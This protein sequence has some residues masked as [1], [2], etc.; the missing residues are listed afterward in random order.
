MN[1]ATM[2]IVISAID[3]ASQVIKKVEG[4][5]KNAS[6]KIKE[7]GVQIAKAG[8]VMSGIAAP[9]IGA[10][11]MAI[12]TGIDFEQQMKNVQSVLGGT[13][14][15]F[16]KLSDYA[17]EMG[18]S[19]VFSASEA[20]QAMY[21]MASAGMKTEQ[22]M[23]SLKSTLDLA[24]AT[25]SDLAQT[26]DVVVSTLSQFSLPAE[27]ASR[28]A[29]VFASA[30][31]NSKASLTSLQY[32]MKYVGPVAKSL[33]YSLE[34]T[35]AALMM[36]YQ[37][38]YAGEQ[39]G[40]I[41]RGALSS[42]L[43]PSNDAKK[44]I[45][46]YGLQ[47]YDTQ[48]NL[49]SFTKIL[50]ELQDA[51]LSTAE[52]ITIFGQEAGPGVASMLNQGV[53]AYQK[54]L[55][56]LQ[57][58]EG[59]S[60]KMAEEQVNSV[61]GAIKLIKSELESIEIEIFNNMKSEIVSILK[62]FKSMLPIIKEF[63]EY[64]IAGFKQALDYIKPF[65]NKL[66]EFFHNIPDNIKKT[67]ALVTGLGGAFAVIAGPALLAIGGIVSGLGSVIG[68][69]SSVAGAVSGISLSAIASSALPVVAAIGAIIV[70]L[71]ALKKIWDNNL[72]GFRTTA[73]EFFNN[74]KNAIEWV[75]NKIKNALNPVIEKHSG[76]IQ[77][78]Q[79]VGMI[80]LTVLGSAFSAFL[81]IQMQVWG[82]LKKAYDENIFHFRDF[83][84]GIG[85]LLLFLLDKFLGGIGWLLDSIIWLYNN[86]NAIW[87]Q[88]S[89]VV[90][91]FVDFFVDIAKFITNAL[92]SIAN[93]VIGI[94]GKMVRV[95]ENSINGIVG[96]VNRLIS[97]YNSIA[98]K[99]GL[100]RLS[101]LQK[102]SLEKYVPQKIEL[103]PLEQLFKELD[104]GRD[105]LPNIVYNVTINSPTPLTPSKVAKEIARVNRQ[106]LGG[107]F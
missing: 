7:M 64:F 80:A 56:T 19:S 2:Q 72:G 28:V 52:I 58:A 105:T 43:K 10:M 101:Y 91:G 54:Y 44:L 25:Q 79:E 42:L 59:T 63:V 33:N 96:T 83:V 90:N 76:L 49:K 31:S 88:I 34:E 57:K 86:W 73:I 75:V 36:L 51:H 102:I 82:L 104:T 16:K 47:L 94:W 21:Y 84:D 17:V 9:F 37:A 38:G 55:E 78:F 5:V 30:I 99:L 39:A 61:A 107:G 15:D 48:G 12:K 62:V 45:E 13:Q 93:F 68:M 81:N 70:G 6:E 69:I 53:E 66:L 106:I 89:G 60:T 26:S 3:N 23:Q 98:K 46:E 29:D 67:I 4:S 24:A 40:T 50:K 20:A 32:S 95:I 92:V 22:I 27:Q 18:K 8:A 85:K 97:W 41:L 14:E 74:L 65:G 103:S 1:N 35:T 100:P 77:K 11:G 71:L 87:Q